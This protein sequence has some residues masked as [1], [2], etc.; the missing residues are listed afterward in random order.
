MITKHAL[1]LKTT[2]KAVKAQ[3]RFQETKIKISVPI[4]DFYRVL[5]VVV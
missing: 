2:L 3:P 4:T 5:S 1:W